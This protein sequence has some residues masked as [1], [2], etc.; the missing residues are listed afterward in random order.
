MAVTKSL[1]FQ[2][3]RRDNHACRYCGAMA[4]DVKLH[5]DH[6]TP[7][8]LGGT[9]DAANLVTAC[10]DCNRGKSAVPPDAQ[11]VAD[12]EQDNIRWA[13]AMKRAAEILSNEHAAQ[14]EYVHAFYKHA[15]TAHLDLDDNWETSIILFYRH[16]LPL[17]IL[18]DCISITL[19]ARGLPASREFR[20]LCGVAWK[21]VAK[22]Q[23][24]ARSI[25][26]QEAN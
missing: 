8:A 2:V 21:R 9:D 18:I 23:D 22:L 4:P 25:A 11:L 10:A 19:R 20:Y 24:I 17:E 1:R 6:V 13:A 12:V 3:L 15:A 5:I 14:D 26:E 7:V 16:G